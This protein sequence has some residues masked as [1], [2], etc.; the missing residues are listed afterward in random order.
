MVDWRLDLKATACGEGLAQ[1]ISLDHQLFNR[2]VSAALSN[3]QNPA[4]V[5]G[6]HTHTSVFVVWMCKPKS[7]GARVMK[8]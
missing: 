3:Q 5:Y 2:D 7:A 8:Q 6:A 1:S 4:A